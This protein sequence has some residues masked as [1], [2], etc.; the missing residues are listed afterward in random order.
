[1]KCGGVEYVCPLSLCI[2][3]TSEVQSTG[4]NTPNKKITCLR[5]SSTY[6]HFQNISWSGHYP[7]DTVILRNGQFFPCYFPKT[8][9]LTHSRT[10]NLCKVFISLLLL[11]LRNCVTNGE[12]Y[13]I[14]RFSFPDNLGSNFWQCFWFT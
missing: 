7:M 10:K 3:V 1:M 4:A 13:Y 12:M 14:L 9:T 8:L 11:V 6:S 5:G 2:C